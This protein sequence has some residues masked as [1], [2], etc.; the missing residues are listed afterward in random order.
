VSYLVD[1]NVI[2]ELYKGEKCDPCVARW[3]DSI[4]DEDLF[5][6][7]LVLGEIRKG[8][9]KIR[10][11]DPDRAKIIEIWLSGLKDIFDDRVLPVDSLIADKWGRMSARR[12]VP[13]VDCLLAATARIHGLTIVTRNVRD[14]EGLD[15]PMINPFAP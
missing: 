5:I 10:H 6:S 14:Y 1:T 9:E 2:S 12:S 7:V 4:G 15:V 11:R 3:Y 8:A 13:I